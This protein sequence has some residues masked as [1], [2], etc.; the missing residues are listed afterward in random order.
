MK[1]EQRKSPL[2]VLALALIALPALADS[3]SIGGPVLGWL[4]DPTSGLRAIQGIPGACVMGQPLDL[5]LV[6]RQ[7]A[8]SPRQD[9][10]IAAVGDNLDLVVIRVAQGAASATPLAQADR[11]PDLISLSPAGSS[12]ALY[13][14]A[15]KKIRVLAGLPEAPAVAGEFDLS[16]FPAL[17]TAV[18]VSDDAS[19]ALAAFREETA[20]SVF[21]LAAGA[22]PQF[23]S[24]FGDVPAIAFVGGTGNAVIADSA[25]NKIYLLRSGRGPVELLAGAGDGVAGPVAVAISRDNRKVFVANRANNTVTALDLAGSTGATSALPCPCTPTGLFPLD[26][27][28]VFRLVDGGSQPIWLLDGDGS[29]PRVVFVPAGGGQ[30]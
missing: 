6:I 1:L 7:A 26:G 28:A 14:S 15:A 2:R 10:V 27:N 24:V 12:A 16:S 13:Y 20:A 3:S 9:Y 8:I 4:F 17:V 5:E 30:P 19:L 25:E 11:G 29:A 22:T 18:G 21:M 23:L